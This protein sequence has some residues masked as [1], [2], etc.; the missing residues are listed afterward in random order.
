MDIAQD[1]NG[2]RAADLTPPKPAMIDAN[3]PD[4]LPKVVRGT[5]G[6]SLPPF[7]DPVPPLAEKPVEAKAE[8]KPVDAPAPKSTVVA[9]LPTLPPVAEQAPAEP[10]PASV[11]RTAKPEESAGKVAMSLTFAKDKS[12]V[13][14]EMKAKI[15]NV[16]KEIKSSGASVRVVSYAT[17]TDGEQSTARRIALS[18]AL[19]VR[20][21]LMEQGVDQFK[22]VPQAL[23]NAKNTDQ[24]DLITK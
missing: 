22:I 24:V 1:S 9:S 17:G 11:A 2:V 8:A 12:D 15:A 23:G 4:T 16:A 18:R 14:P 7:P 19:Q 5:P 13:D 3:A 21:L 20:A 10:K 6:S